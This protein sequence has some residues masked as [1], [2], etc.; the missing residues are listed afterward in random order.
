MVSYIAIYLHLHFSFFHT[1]YQSS[2]Y[3]WGKH[4]FPEEQEIQSND[5]VI[6]A[7]CGTQ[8]FIS[9]FQKILTPVPILNPVFNLLPCFP[10]MNF[11]I[12]PSVF[13]SSKFLLYSGYPVKFF[14]TF[15]INQCIFNYY[16]LK[17]SLLVIANS[18]TRFYSIFIHD[19]SIF[20]QHISFYTALPIKMLFFSCLW[21]SEA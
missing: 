2:L 18:V 17:V 12:L 8:R 5:E 1:L 13:R 16:E 15:I 4:I 14:N 3:T 10:N 21:A 11:H 6:S 20:I 9:M 19:Q 7:F